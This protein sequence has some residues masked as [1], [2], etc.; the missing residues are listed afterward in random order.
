MN[1]DREP[2]ASDP[3]RLPETTTPGLDRLPESPDRLLETTTV[4]WIPGRNRLDIVLADRLPG[5]GTVTSAFAFVVDPADRTLLTFVDRTGR[6]WEIPGGHLDPGESPVEA[7][8]RELAEETGLRLE[9][10]RLSVFAWHRAELLDRPPVG[11]PYPALTY[12]VWFRARLTVPG[13]FTRPAAGSECTRARW[14][15]R[16]EVER[17]GA[18]RTWL[19]TYR[20]LFG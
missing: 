3:D 20:A 15:A 17:L 9:P 18:G 1:D 13:P 14:L 2:T 10:E 11:Y 12:M 5:S 7:A 16:E 8:V 19:T 4:A 6:G